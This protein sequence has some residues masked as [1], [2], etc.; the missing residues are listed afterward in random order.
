[1]LIRIMDFTCNRL[2]AHAVDVSV[3]KYASVNPFIQS[4]YCRSDFGF[5]LIKPVQLFI[6]FPIELNKAVEFVR[7][8]G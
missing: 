2:E 4:P 7:I 1:M 3:F 8:I 6:Y 5:N